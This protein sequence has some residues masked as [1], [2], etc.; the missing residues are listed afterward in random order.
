MNLQELTLDIKTPSG[1]TGPILSK[2]FVLTMVKLAI[3]NNS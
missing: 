2:A 1:T 3:D